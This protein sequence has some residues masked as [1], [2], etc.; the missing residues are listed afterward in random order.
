MRGLRGRVAA[1]TRK[2]FSAPDDL[3]SL[4][5]ASSDDALPN[6]VLPNINGTISE[7][8]LGIIVCWI[9]NTNAGANALNGAALKIR[10]KKSTGAWGTDDLA[11]IDLAD[12]SLYTLASTTRGGIFLVGDN[13]I[14]SEVD[15]FNATY[16]SRFEDN[17]IDNDNIKLYDVQ[18]FLEV[19][20][21]AN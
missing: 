9:E 20:F 14:S 10:T 2:W 7:V 19:T 17:I 1:Q 6:V 11:A 13:D 21:K 4:T 18:C 5:Q 12:N 3:I 15:V 16:N 8:Y